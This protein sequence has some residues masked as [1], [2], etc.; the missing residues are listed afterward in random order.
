MNGVTGLAVSWA[1]GSH[2]ENGIEAS[3]Y[4]A[5][6]FGDRAGSSAARDLAT[7]LSPGSPRAGVPEPT[8]RARQVACDQTAESPAN[9]PC[10][11]H[12]PHRPNHASQCNTRVLF[13]NFV[14]KPYLTAASRIVNYRRFARSALSCTDPC[15]QEPT[16]GLFSGL[17]KLD[18]ANA[19]PQAADSRLRSC[20]S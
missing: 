9:E 14:P 16:C 12:A 13:A 8:V 5:Q 20:P 2:S 6:V 7:R 10:T 15:S 18:L 1:A 11:T 17:T 4:L 19:W 3:K